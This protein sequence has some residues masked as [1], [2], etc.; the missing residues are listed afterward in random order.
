M[1]GCR[2]FDQ[3]CERLAQAPWV[4]E[5][6]RTLAVR[7]LRVEQLGDSG[8]NQA[9][10][11]GGS[12]TLSRSAGQFSGEVEYPCGQAGEVEHIVHDMGEVE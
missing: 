11:N 10:P 2:D 1:E 12:G 5:S 8:P 6:A 9:L 3:S 4:P 7:G